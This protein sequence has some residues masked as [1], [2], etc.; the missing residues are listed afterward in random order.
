MRN[1]FGLTERK[2]RY[3]DF[4]F[5]YRITKETLFPIIAEVTEVNRSRAFTKD[6]WD[7]NWKHI[8]ILQKGNRRIGYYALVDKG[9]GTG[10]ILKLFLSPAYQG[11]G[12]GTFLL[13]DFERRG[14]KRLE[15][16]VW[17]NNPAVRLYKRLGYK[18]FK[19]TKTHYGMRKTL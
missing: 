11:K 13:K 19:T 5:F 15:L 8:K 9:G 1:P 17:K 7:K 10:Y 2:A 16:S 18:V 3:S 6:N 12:I 4:A 14:F